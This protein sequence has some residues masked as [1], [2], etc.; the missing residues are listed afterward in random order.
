[1]KLSQGLSGLP[2]PPPRM[3]ALKKEDFHMDGT[4]LKG[5][6]QPRLEICWKIRQTQE[7]S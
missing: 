6:G 1:M 4:M 2:P 5:L 3:G 7:F